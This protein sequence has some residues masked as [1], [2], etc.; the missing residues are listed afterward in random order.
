VN[1]VDRVG[2]MSAPAVARPSRASTPVAAQ[3]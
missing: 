2:N 3:R 1:A